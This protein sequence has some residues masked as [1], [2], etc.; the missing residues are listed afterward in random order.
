MKIL[1]QYFL[2]ACLALVFVAGCENATTERTGKIFLSSDTA[3]ILPPGHPG[4]VSGSTLMLPS[5]SDPPAVRYAN[6]FAG[7]PGHLDFG[8]GSSAGA[9]RTYLGYAVLPV[10]INLGDTVLGAYRIRIDVS[11]PSVHIDLANIAG[12][13]SFLSEND[14]RKRGCLSGC[15]Q[16]PA[17]YPPQFNPARGF[18]IVPVFTGNIAGIT[19]EATDQDPVNPTTGTANLCNIRVN[20]AG[21]LPLGRTWLDFTVDLLEDSSGQPITPNPISGVVIENFQ[22]Q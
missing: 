6:C 20:I 22:I 5:E 11:H 1:A 15:E 19:V 2:C 16:Y 9:T 17:F 18:E 7:V 21:D 13:N 4:A 3:V 10:N 14:C 8:I 12:S